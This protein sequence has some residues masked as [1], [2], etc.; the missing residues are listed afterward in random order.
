MKKPKKIEIKK[1]ITITDLIPDMKRD[2][3]EM[4]KEQSEVRFYDRLL[5]ENIKKLSDLIGRKI[6]EKEAKKVFIIVERY[7]PKLRDGNIIEYFPFDLAWNIYKILKKNNFDEGCLKSR[8]FDENVFEIAKEHD[9]SLVE[10]EELQRF[11][12]EYDF[13]DADDLYEAWSS[14]K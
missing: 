9:L 11:S 12:D 3:Q 4:Q 5:D 13:K 10:T 7:S 6:T 1:E 14:D 8:Y 2:I